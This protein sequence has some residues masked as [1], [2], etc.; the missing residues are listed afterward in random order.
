[1][2]SSVFLI[3]VLATILHVTCAGA[4]FSLTVRDSIMIAHSFANNP[5]FG[6]A[7]NLHGATYTV[8]VTFKA[9]N[10]HRENNWVVDIGEAS[11][12]LAEV[13]GRFNFKN[14]DEL[15]PG[16]MTTTEVRVR[17]SEGRGTVTQRACRLFAYA[18]DRCHSSCAR[19]F[20]RVSGL[21]GRMGPGGGGSRATLWLG[22]TDC[23]QRKNKQTKVVHGSNPVRA[24]I[25]L[26]RICSLSESHKAWASYEGKA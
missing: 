1:M 14:L 25:L 3:T 21:E 20:L 11:E 26:Y 17:E 2:A 7:Q 4:G 8:D 23:K 5:S 13:C 10:L 18:T 6:P 24:I 16:E 19:R 15:F 9:K 22:E 12:I